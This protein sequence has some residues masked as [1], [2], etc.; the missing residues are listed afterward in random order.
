MSAVQVPSLL[1][2]GVEVSARLLYTASAIKELAFKSELDA[3]C[4]ASSGAHASSSSFRLV[5]LT[6]L[7]M[8]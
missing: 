3:L 6:G 7:A 2:R 8:V 1:Q 5:T 4:R